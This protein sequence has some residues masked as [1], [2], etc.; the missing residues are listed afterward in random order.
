MLSKQII[1]KLRSLG[2]KLDKEHKTE[3]AEWVDKAIEQH[4]NS[5]IQDYK[6][7]CDTFTGYDDHL[8]DSRRVAPYYESG[9]V[10][11]YVGDKVTGEFASFDN[12]KFGIVKFGLFDAYWPTGAHEWAYAYGFY[13]QTEVYKD[14]YA[15]NEIEGLSKC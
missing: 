2:Y 14:G 9:G 11:Y 10:E 5:R 4:A 3:F 12:S 15:I 7:V 6:D 13:V 8:Y 1:N